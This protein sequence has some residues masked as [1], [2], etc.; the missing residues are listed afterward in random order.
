MIAESVQDLAGFG[1]YPLQM[2]QQDFALA[3]V[4]LG[5]KARESGSQLLRVNCHYTPICTVLLR[6]PS[7][8][9]GLRAIQVE[10]EYS[11]VGIAY[12]DINPWNGLSR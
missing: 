6:R 3:A 8:L 11:L 5:Q 10:P 9:L 7:V 1:L 4:K 12:V 2:L